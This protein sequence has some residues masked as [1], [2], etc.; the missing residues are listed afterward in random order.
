MKALLRRIIHS[1]GYE[2][3]F[4]PRYL[5]DHPEVEYTPGID[6]I[7]ARALLACEDPFF[8]HIGAFDGVANDPLH[9]FLGR[10]CFSGIL[11]EPQPDVFEKLKATYDGLKGI[12]FENCAV[13]TT[14]GELPLFRLKEDYQYLGGDVAKQI[15]SPYREKIEAFISWDSDTSQVIEEISVPSLTVG[16]L[17]RKH[18]R[19]RVDLLLVDTEGYDYE[20]LKST[21]LQALKP[22]LILYEHKHLNEADQTACWDMLRNLGYKL[23]IYWEDTV[24]VDPARLG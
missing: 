12:S 6:A 24:A 22:C 1:L 18:G 10:E 23:F 5:L 8:I 21:D 13:G 11:V 16:S 7:I 4:K 19:D 20:I 3:S 15:T 9:P 14:D 17:L 2:I